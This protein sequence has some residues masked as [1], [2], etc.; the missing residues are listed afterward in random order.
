MALALRTAGPTAHLGTTIDLALVVWVQESSQEW[1]CG[2]T[3]PAPH[4][5]KAGELTLLER[6]LTDQISFYPGPD[7]GP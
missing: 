4:L 5:G 7:P 3:I 2:K 6:Q 1:E